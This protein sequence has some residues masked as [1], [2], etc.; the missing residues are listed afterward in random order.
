MQ[1][2]I[3]LHVYTVVHVHMLQLKIVLRIKINVL[4]NVLA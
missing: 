2:S 3:L 1:Y 4:I